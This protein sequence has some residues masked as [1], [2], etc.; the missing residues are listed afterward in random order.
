MNFKFVILCCA[1]FTTSSAFAGSGIIYELNQGAGYIYQG[2]KWQ[3]SATVG[4]FSDR[5]E[6]Q[7]TQLAYKLTVRRDIFKV[8]TTP[9]T[10]GLTFAQVREK[11]PMDYVNNT[12]SVPMGVRYSLSSNLQ[13]DF[14]VN[15]F[16]QQEQFVYD[17]VT[18]EKAYDGSRTGD[19]FL[20]SGGLSLSL[21]L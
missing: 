19:K 16:S 11:S 17:S 1:F 3:G 4:Y 13:L 10:L 8:D 9:V 5:F 15:I 2:E 6:S 21:F 14:F 7:E 12:L 20:S 18:N